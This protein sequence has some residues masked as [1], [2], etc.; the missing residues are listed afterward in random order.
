YN[1]LFQ[2]RSADAASASATTDSAAAPA[3]RLGVDPQVSLPGVAAQV[4]N[5][6][7]GFAGALG[8]QPFTGQF[9]IA[10][11]EL[12]QV[13]RGSLITSLSFRL[14]P[15][16]AAWPASGTTSGNFEIELASAA[17]PNEMM[18]ESFPDNRGADAI[19]VRSGPLTLDAGM[20]P[21]GD[22]GSFGG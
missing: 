15:G 6:H 4:S 14:A 22:S 16:G 1:E 19:V 21:A 5:G 10:A 18:S 3:T 8:N 13:V 9:L 20:F 11:S 12:R 2:A 17:L 7:T